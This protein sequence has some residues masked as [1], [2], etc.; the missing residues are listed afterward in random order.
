YLVLMGK[1]N[2]A[3]REMQRARELDPLSLTISHQTG[4]VLYYA[5]RY[6]EAIERFRRTLEID[7]TFFQAQR[8]I[9]RP[10][11]EEG[12]Y[13]QAL[14]EAEKAS[15]L[16]VR[17]YLVLS[18]LGQTYA[19]TRRTSDAFVIL[20]QLKEGYKKSPNSTYA[21]ASVYATLN[22]KDQAL[23]WLEKAYK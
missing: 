6:D 7:P 2:D 23:D 13:Q 5:R 18:L 21:I 19:R 17:D 9:G 15:K 12:Q 3:I 10:Y 22:E 8:D 14:A 16:K 11:L 4:L 20:K 1:S